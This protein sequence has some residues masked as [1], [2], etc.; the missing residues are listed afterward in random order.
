MFGRQLGSVIL[1]EVTDCHGLSRGLPELTAQVRDGRHSFI[2]IL[3]INNNSLHTLEA[4]CLSTEERF[5]S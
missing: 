2:F 5:I 1:A 3:V 4:S